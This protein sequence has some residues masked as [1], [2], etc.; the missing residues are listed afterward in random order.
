MISSAMT[1]KLQSEIVEITMS[2]LDWYIINQVKKLR[3]KKGISQ[4]HLSVE[5][6]FSEKLIG[7]IENPTHKAKYNIRHL[8]LLA[9][10]LGCSIW[11][12]IPEK[13]VENDLVSIKVKRTFMV[14]QKGKLI[15]KT[16][17]EILNIKPQKRR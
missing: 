2:Q 3:N 12:I 13:P 17:L 6:G 7:S 8:N 10:A 15:G 11:D 9:S 1:G 14:N 5:M 4:A 16:K